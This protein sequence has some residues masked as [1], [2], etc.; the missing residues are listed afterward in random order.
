MYADTIDFFAETAAKKVKAITNNPLGFFIAAMMAGAYVGLGI[1]AIFSI[2]QGI[3]PG[4]RPLAMGLTFAIALTLV[5]F[6]GAEL[7]TGHTMM[8]TLGVLKGKATM[9]GLGRSW[10]MTWVG[11]LAGAVALAALFWLGGGG[12]ILKQGADLAYS[13]ADAKMHAAPLALVAKGI[14]CNWLVCLAL[15]TSA[16][17]T[18]DAAKL[19]LIFWCLFA[20]IASGF[21]HSVA[22]MTLFAITLFG[23]HPDTITI[24]GM[25]YNLLW[26]SIGNTI[27]GVVFVAGGYYLANGRVAPVA[28][29]NAAVVPAE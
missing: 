10:A 13:V 23:N 6:A 18:N 20:F 14:L 9:S 11:N 21:E 2:G 19:I 25:F 4:I 26:V 29:V 3:D 24:G 28:S 7:F 22:N 15:W 8:M 5:V 17:T 1:I 16:R 12:A 27:A